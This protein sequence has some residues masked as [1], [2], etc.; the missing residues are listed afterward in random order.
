AIL[1]IPITMEIFA[2]ISSL[3]LG[4]PARSIAALVFTTVLAPL[5]SGIAVRVMAPSFAER[6]VKPLAI[7]AMVLLVLT[8]VPVF[9]ASIRSIFS[10]IGEGTLLSFTVFALAGYLIGYLLG[11]PEPENRRVLGIATASR[12]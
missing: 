12:H 9:L 2:R 11:G 1:V 3:S 6:F 10:L 5:L 7:F 8:V 4:M